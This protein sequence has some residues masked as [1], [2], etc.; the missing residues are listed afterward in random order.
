MR[1]RLERTT[2]YPS[3]PSRRRGGPAASPS[4][5]GPAR[6]GSAD[7]LGVVRSLTER[8]RF[9]VSVLAEHQVLT[10]TQLA[11][12]CFP[13][14][15]VAQRRLLRLTR[16]GVLDRFRWH[17]LVGSEAWHYTLGPAGAA[18]VAAERGAEPPRPAELRRRALRLAASPRLTHLLGVNGFFC[19]LGAQARSEPGCALVSWWS[20]RRCAE[21]YGELVRPDA[22]GIWTEHGRQ[23]GFFVEYDTGTEPLARLAAKLAGYA[24][25]AAAGGPRHPVCFWLPTTAREAHLRRL[26]AERPR[27]VI[28]AT[29]SAELAVALGTGPAEAIWLTAGAERRRRLIDLPAPNPPTSPR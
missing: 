20:E 7:P 4:P 8:D 6:S 14:L 3:A 15:D 16:L 28:V 17:A 5:S 27:D 1:P 29:A 24:E 19:A 9:C 12:L 21:H 11:Q 10:T 25:L 18:L 23:V 13:S 2:P 22:Q 26:L